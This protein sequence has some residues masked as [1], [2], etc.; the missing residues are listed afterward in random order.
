MLFIM[1]DQ[2]SKFH[3]G[4]Y[5][6]PLVRTPHLDRLASEGMTFTNAYTAAQS[7]SRRSAFAHVATGAVILN[8]ALTGT[9]SAPRTFRSVVGELDPDAPGLK[10][11]LNPHPEFPLRT[12]PIFPGVYPP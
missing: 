6:E 3:L 9:R 10:T 7:Q 5:S 11:P 12:G 1:P 2:H 8:G 4:F